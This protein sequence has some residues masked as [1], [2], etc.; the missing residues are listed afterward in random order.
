MG[1]NLDHHSEQIITDSS[2]RI[3]IF[4]NE[5]RRP[6]VDLVSKHVALHLFAVIHEHH[7]EDFWEYFDQF[8]V[9]DEAG[10]PQD[11]AGSPMSFDVNC[12]A[13][14]YVAFLCRSCL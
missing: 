4:P 1:T 2:Q 5:D 6:Q 12:R 13:R 10:R 8:G 11:G 3:T 14:K 9:Y 7:A